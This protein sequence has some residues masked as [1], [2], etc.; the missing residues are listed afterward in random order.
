MPWAE[1]TWQQPRARGSDRERAAASEIAHVLAAPD[2]WSTGQQD[3]QGRAIDVVA[4]A[5]QHRAVVTVTGLGAPPGDLVHQLWAAE[6][7]GSPRSLGLLDG[8]TPKVVAGLNIAATSLAVTAG[9]AGGSPRPTSTPLVQLA[10][11]SIG[12]GE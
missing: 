5:S 6:K 4:S 8:D 2:A 10:L 3:A 7:S 9:P 12:F 1:A 11:E